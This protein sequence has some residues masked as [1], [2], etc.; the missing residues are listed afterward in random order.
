MSSDKSLPV[1]ALD[2]DG[3]LALMG[4]HEHLRV[5]EK[6]IDVIPVVISSDL[7]ARLRLLT[8][9]FRIVWASSWG[10]RA[11]Q[12][13][14]TLV[15]LPRGLPFIDFE[16]YPNSRVGESYKLPGL[17]T[18]LKSLPAAVVD[19]EVGEDMRAWAAERPDTLVVEVDPRFGLQ[20]DHVSQ[21]LEF[22]IKVRAKSS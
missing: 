20:E 14:A 17:R 21:L 5:V 3:P 11:S 2:V 9:H 18:W 4:S 15:G 22:S 10:K 1:L 12:K 7:P 8:A 13:I 6:R 19:D 16:K